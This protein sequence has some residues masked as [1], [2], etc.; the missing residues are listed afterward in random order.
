MWALIITLVLVGLILLG[1]ELLVI[2]G[3]GVVG[4]LGLASFVA[5]CYLAFVNFGAV[6]GAAVAVALV[7]LVSVFVVLVLRSKTWKRITL[8]T[9][10]DSRIDDTPQSKGIEVGAIGVALT[11]LAPA[12]QA[13]LGDIALE[14]FSRDSIIAAG[15]A[16]EVVEVSDNKVFVKAVTK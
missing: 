15:S 12:G 11:R 8:D 5:S 13:E 4:V 9:S 7:V 1:I 2:P 3:F 6:A 10:I 16:V 14:V